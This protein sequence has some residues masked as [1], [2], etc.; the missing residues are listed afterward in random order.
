MSLKS[1]DVRYEYKRGKGPGGQHRNK[2]NSCVKAIHIPTGLHVEIDGRKQH[3]NKKAAL[4][5]LTRLV[6]GEADAGK[7]AAKKARR[8]EKIQPENHI[9]TYDLRRGEVIDLR[10]R[11]RARVKDILDKGR[12]ELLR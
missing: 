11:K 9:R 10:T 7:A 6:Q 1:E 4:A 2:T 8:D 12:L 5:E 3:Q